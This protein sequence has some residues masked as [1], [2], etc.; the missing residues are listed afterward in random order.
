MNPRQSIIIKTLACSLLTLACPP[1]GDPGGDTSGPASSTTT[2]AEPTTHTPTTSSDTSSVTTDPT[3][4]SGSPDSSSGDPATDTG[5][6]STGPGAPPPTCGDGQLDPGEECDDGLDN[7]DQARC[8]LECEL[9][10]C[11]DDLIWQGHESCDEGPNNNDNLYGGCT[12]Q[13][14]LGPTCNDG[15]VQPP[16]ECDLADANG[17]GESPAP[18]GV[19]CDDGCRFSARLV[20]LSSATYKGGD[21]GGVEG[22]DIKCQLLA[23]Q[24]GFDNAINFKA[25]LSDAQ[26]SPDLDFAHPPETAN[27]PYVRP[28]GVRIADGWNDLT[29]NGP[30]YGITVTDTGEKLLNTFVWTGTAPSGKVFDPAATCEAWSSSASTNK[31]RLGKSG[32]DKQAPEWSQWS[33]ERRW[34]NFA[35]LEC[36][37]PY[38]IYCFEQ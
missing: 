33:E 4:T 5:T 12:T 19:P 7:D 10:E 29:L 15:V 34:T 35:S 9:A 31:S 22:A 11:G 3:S 18:D 30:A 38:R 8:T 27:L 17:S 36:H 32:V 28:D 25:W 14:Q 20:F 13:C 6:A 2:G 16:E 26:H 37:W 24:A 21:L 1:T 23:G